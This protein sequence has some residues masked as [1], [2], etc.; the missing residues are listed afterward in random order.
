MLDVQAANSK[1]NVFRTRKVTEEKYEAWSRYMKLYIMNP[2]F[3]DQTHDAIVTTILSYI[4]GPDVDAWVTNYC[5]QHWDEDDGW[6]VTPADLYAHLDDAFTDKNAAPNARA[7]IRSLKQGTMTADEYFVK[8]ES[9]LKTAGYSK[10]DLNVLEL[11]EKNVNQDVIDMIYT[12][13][14]MPILYGEWKEKIL[15]LDAMRRR[16][17][18]NKQAQKKFG[19][20]P[21]TQG[22]TQ[23]QQQ[24]QYGQ[25][26]DGTGT[27]YTGTGQPMDIDR[28]RNGGPICKKCG[29]PKYRKGTCGSPWH[30]EPTTQQGSSTQN[31]RV[32]QLDWQQNDD[33]QLM[34]ETM[35]K[36]Q[37]DDPDGFKNAG[38]GFGTA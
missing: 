6:N 19:W 16:R 24:Q 27:T 4:K 10:S 20:N 28:N 3:G 11:L 14:P 17:E 15:N 36:W 8:F 21:K 30:K 32:R 5:D 31:Q 18:G 13:D 9:L 34:I 22:Q 1:L 37:K 2:S 29:I 26:R 7:K 35:K 12:H 38:F 25:R 33:K 23:P